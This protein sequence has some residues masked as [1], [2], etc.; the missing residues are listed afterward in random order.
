MTTKPTP[1]ATPEALDILRTLQTLE[2]W[3]TR[4]KNGTVSFDRAALFDCAADL[5]RMF[6]EMPVTPK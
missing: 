6:R 2:A 5:V 3:G 1:D 4:K